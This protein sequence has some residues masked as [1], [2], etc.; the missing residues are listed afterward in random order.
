MPLTNKHIIVTRAAHQAEKLVKILQ[1]KEA[2]PLIYPCIDIATLEN[3]SELDTALRNLKTYDWLI[4]TSSNTVLALCRRMGAL[5]LHIDWSQIKIAAVGHSTA[6]VAE[7]LFGR[8][9]DFIS[10]EHTGKALAETL[11]LQDSIHVFLPQS[12]VAGVE[13]SEILQSRGIDVTVVSAY[14]NIIG[15]GGD[16]ISLY[17]EEN[18][19]DAITFTSGSTV[20]GF[21]QRIKPLTA[22]DLPV[23][24]IGSSTAEVAQNYGFKNIIVPKKNTL[25]DMLEALEQHF[26]KIFVNKNAVEN[27]SL[28]K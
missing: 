12:D 9:P 10:E 16:N 11:P 28:E 22:Y 3:S 26:V 14:E 8:K 24:C 23:V 17:L 27:N 1:D 2:V 18:R 20:E 5:Q 4:L 25:K 13:T 19:V 15:Q 7:S 21:I 6:S